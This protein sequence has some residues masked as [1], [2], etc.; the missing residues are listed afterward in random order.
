[1]YKLVEVVGKEEFDDDTKVNSVDEAY[2]MIKQMVSGQVNI[3]LMQRYDVIKGCWILTW[4]D[5]NHYIK[6]IN[7]K[8][9]R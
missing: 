7:D 4:G 8:G 9:G 2:K 1:M 3:I 5:N 6:V